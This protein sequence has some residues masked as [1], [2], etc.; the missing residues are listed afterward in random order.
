VLVAVVG[1]D[2]AALAG[3]VLLEVGLGLVA[4]GGGAGPGGAGVA[5]L[6]LELGLGG[7]VAGDQ[8]LHAAGVVLLEDL[9]RVGGDAGAVRGVV[10]A[11]LD[12]DRAAQLGELVGLVIE[13]GREGVDGG[14]EGELELREALDDALDRIPSGAGD[15]LAVGGLLGGL[16]LGGDDGDLRLKGAEQRRE[17]LEDLVP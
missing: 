12:L 7:G 6:L 2:L 1:L 13:V 4:L 9:E 8:R 3:E 15:D 16:G 10:A 17:R 11:A 14:G 5:D